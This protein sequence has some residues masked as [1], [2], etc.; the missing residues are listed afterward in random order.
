MIFDLGQSCG[1]VDG[2]RDPSGNQDAEEAEQIIFPRRQHDRHGLARL[3]SVRGETG[4]YGS[5]AVLQR[6]VADV[7][8]GL[9]L[10]V[11]VDVELAGMGANVPVKDLHQGLR[12]RREGARA[13]GQRTQ[14]VG[15]DRDGRC[16]ASQQLQEVARR[17]RRNQSLFR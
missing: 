3:Q 8:D 1:R 2:Y 6:Q 14:L 4:R 12:V 13:L 10:G 7:F 16:C 17:F 9:T 5:R 15:P 11:Q